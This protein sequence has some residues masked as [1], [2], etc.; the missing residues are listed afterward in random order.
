VCFIKEVT[1]KYFKLSVLYGRKRVEQRRSLMLAIQSRYQQ[2]RML[3]ALVL[4]FP[5][6]R[7]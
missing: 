4:S 2:R 3:L 7:P 6:V 1:L 5:F